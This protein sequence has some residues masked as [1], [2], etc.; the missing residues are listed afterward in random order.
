MMWFECLF[1]FWA[2]SDDN[3]SSGFKLSKSLSPNHQLKTVPKI[4]KWWGI[5]ALLSALVLKLR[6]WLNCSWLLS[7]PWHLLMS[8][9]VIACLDTAGSQSGAILG[10]VLW[11]FYWLMI[12][13]E[14]GLPTRLS[15][16]WVAIQCEKCNV[17]CPR[18]IT[19]QLL[20]GN[21]TTCKFFFL[22]NLI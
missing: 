3:G 20:Y 19:C 18:F 4:G 6:D 14:A 5:L 15:G 11:F 1:F 12:R 7:S 21:L 10:R 16:A 22:A 17:R 13:N 2:M 8:F 9:S